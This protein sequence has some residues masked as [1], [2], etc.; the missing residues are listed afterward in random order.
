MRSDCF[1]DIGEGESTPLCGVLENPKQSKSLQAKKLVEH[2]VRRVDAR[3]SDVRVDI[4]HV[5]RPKPL[6]RSGVNTS[7]WQWRH[8]ISHRIKPKLHINVL[9][10]AAIDTAMKWRLRCRAR[11][12]RVLHLTDSQVCLSAIA[13]GRTSSSRLRGT[14]R[15][16]GARLVGGGIVLTLGYTTSET[17]PAD[18][19]SRQG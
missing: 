18:E 7:R 10:L 4:G 6:H 16:I 8:V 19:P 11:C 3:G 1:A 12:G 14:L 9:E 15:R 13:K 17:N 5:F 2:F